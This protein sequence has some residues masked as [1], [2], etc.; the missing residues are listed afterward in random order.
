MAKRVLGLVTVLLCALSLAPIVGPVPPALAAVDPAAGWPQFR[1]APDHTGSTSSSSI[2]P[3]NVA[4]LEPAW[5]YNDGSTASSPA[6]VDGVVYVGSSSLG[7]AHSYL[8][9]FAA[10]GKGCSPDANCP[11]L[12]KGE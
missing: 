2:S 5:H 9:A 3:A 11:P 8:Y 12:W 1:G 6:V 4:S 7:A 10:D